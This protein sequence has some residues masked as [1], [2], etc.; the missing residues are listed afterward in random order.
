[1]DPDWSTIQA[2]HNPSGIETFHKQNVSIPLRF[3]STAAPLYNPPSAGPNRQGSEGGAVQMGNSKGN[4]VSKLW[5]GR[6]VKCTHV[7]RISRVKAKS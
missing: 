1:L 7:R 6:N 3:R 5:D 2:L 4:G